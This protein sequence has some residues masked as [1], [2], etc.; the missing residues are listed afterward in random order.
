VPLHLGVT[1]GLLAGTSLVLFTLLPEGPLPLSAWLA[2]LGL[3]LLSDLIEYALHRWPMHK[4]RR[5]TRAF[6]RNH[7]IS[8][9]RYFTYET[10]GMSRPEEVFFVLSSAPVII[11]SVLVLVLTTGALALLAGPQ[12]GMFA[13]GVLGIFATWKQLL[14]VAFHFPDE[15][16]RYPFLRSR[17]F[18]A[19]KEHHTIHHDPRMMRKWNFNIG[20]PL[21]DALFG[22]L[23]WERRR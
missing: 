14:H 12:V 13:G 21:F 7:T 6:F 20:T 15:W 4:R 10:M 17:V 19:M 16:M 9:H 23:T 22:T 1:V 18:Q 2:A 3:V 5:L 8:H 11:L